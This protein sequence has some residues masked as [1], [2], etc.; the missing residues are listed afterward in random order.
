MRKQTR[1]PA[2]RLLTQARATYTSPACV[3]ETGARRWWMEKDFL[4]PEPETRAALR[5]TTPERIS[6]SLAW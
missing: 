6:D 2:T 3:R 4:E 1:R 5:P